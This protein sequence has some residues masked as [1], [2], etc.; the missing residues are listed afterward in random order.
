MRGRI[1]QTNPVEKPRFGTLLQQGPL[2]GEL[3]SQAAMWFDS[4]CHLD[5]PGFDASTS[6]VWTTARAEGV[7]HAFVPGVDPSQWSGLDAVRSLDG[8][9][10]GVGLHPFALER[11]SDL[12]EPLFTQNV[13]GA[14]EKL[15]AEARSSK[16]VAIGEC[17][18]DKPL[19]R[20]CARLDLDMQTQVVVAHLRAAQETR[21]PVVLHVVQAHGLA[22]QTLERHLVPAGG[23][24]HSYSG[25]PELVIRY[26]RLGFRLGF[27]P[28]L[29]RYPKV[30]AAL[31]ATA[32]DFLLLETDAPLAAHWGKWC[33]NSPGAVAAVGR[34]VS[35]ILSIPLIDLAALTSRNAFELFRTG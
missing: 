13:T 3:Q 15:R 29:L 33:A 17:G 1:A 35:E 5:L 25:S 12:P 16:H 20:R 23:V 7:T 34:A 10:T 31:Q 14:L 27:G 21:L 11:W 32:P 19:T 30:V 2:E 22:L 28:P 8:I 18:W 9:T 4:H 6:E 24:V 26:Q